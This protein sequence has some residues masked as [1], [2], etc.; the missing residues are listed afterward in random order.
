MIGEVEKNS[1]VATR[2]QM[3]VNYLAVNYL[4]QKE[5]ENR[6]NTNYLKNIEMQEFVAYLNDF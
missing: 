4:D 3:A 2:K 1:M 5:N 6:Q